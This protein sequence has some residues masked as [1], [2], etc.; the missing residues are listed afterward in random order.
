MVFQAGSWFLRIVEYAI[1]VY[2]VLSW[3]QPRNRAFYWLANFVAPF[4][5]P[6]RRLSLWIT[7]RFR[8]PLDFS[9]W[10]AVFGLH[11][12]NNLWWRLYFILIGLR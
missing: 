7:A 1:L 4:V 11:I 5:R 2:V 8:I 3:F 9:C 12:I 10:F 6:F